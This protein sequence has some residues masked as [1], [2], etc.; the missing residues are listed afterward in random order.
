[1]RS[2]AVLLLSSTLGCSGVQGTPG[3]EGTQGPE[4][5]MGAMG[6]P[7][8]MG[9]TGPTGASGAQG[10]A[11]PPG[12]N[13]TVMIPHLIVSATGE[14]LGPVVNDGCAY[15][16]NAETCYTATFYFDQQGCAGNRFVYGWAH[17][18]AKYVDSTGVVFTTGA[19]P[20]A[21][22]GT[23]SYMGIQPTGPQPCANGASSQPAK[24]L[25]ATG[26]QV[27]PHGQ[28]EFAVELR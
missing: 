21:L 9:A 4:G 2:Y 28:W 1:M 12:P 3:G 6:L 27:I 15:Q 25:V 13:G 10:P 17:A 16:L 20:P 5:P 11:G 14:D 7:G 19:Q 24:L 26:E 8:P 22:V 23:A 18:Q